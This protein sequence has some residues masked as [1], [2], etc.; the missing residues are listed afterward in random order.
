MFVECTT[1]L[2]STIKKAFETIIEGSERCIIRFRDV[3]IEF[4]SV[5]SLNVALLS[6]QLKKEQF[7]HFDDVLSVDIKLEVR[8]FFIFLKRC[9]YDM[10]IQFHDQNVNFITKSRTIISTF[11]LNNNVLDSTRYLDL[12]RS[13]Y[14]DWA[15]FCISPDELSNVILDLAFGGGLTSIC[16]FDDR[17]QWN[18]TFET[19]EIIFTMKN[20]SSGNDN[21]FKIVRKPKFAPIENKYLTKFIK[22]MCTILPN[23][24]SAQV[25]VNEDSPVVFELQLSC[26]SSLQVVIAPTTNVY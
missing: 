19:G 11:C 17:V 16:F 22:Q 25:Y 3:G 21:D 5:D 26:F 23:C 12:N 1:Q 2:S 14:K 24:I 18:S 7:I 4:Q 9:K 8:P 6:F 10:A 20:S 15:M 13:L